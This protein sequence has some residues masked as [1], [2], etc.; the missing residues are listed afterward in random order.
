MLQNTGYG[1]TI[2]QNFG[3][4]SNQDQFSYMKAMY[5]NPYVGPNPM[6]N[7]WE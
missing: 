4:L 3:S 7:P 2:P 6:K 1:S 5:N